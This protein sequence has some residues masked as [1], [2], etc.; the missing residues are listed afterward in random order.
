MDERTKL[1]LKRVKSSPDGADLIEWLETI[2]KDNFISFRGADSKLNDVH[3]GIAIC[4]DRILKAFRQCDKKED[5]KNFDN[6][7]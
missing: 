6:L 2:E 4:I 7:I 3:K 5:I 1:M